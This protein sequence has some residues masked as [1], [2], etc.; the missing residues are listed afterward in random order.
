MGA[1]ATPRPDRWLKRAEGQFHNQDWTEECQGVTH[2]QDSWYLSSNKDGRQGVYRLSLTHQ[3]LGFVDLTGNGSGHLGDI[4]HHQGRIY[5]A[6]EQPVKI[7]VIE[8]TGPWT[9]W[10][11][12]L[13]GEQGQD[14]PQSD[15]PWCAVHPWN[16]LLYSSDFG[17]DA[18]GVSVL[19]AYRLDEPTRQFRHVPAEDITLALPVRRVQG[20]A[21]S[22]NGHVV[23]ASDHTDDIRC[24]STLN[25][26]Y[27]GRA[28]I[29]KDASKFEEVEGITI[30]KD[31][32]YD[33]QPT[34]VHVI[35]LDNDW[36]DGDDIYF[37]HYQVPTAQTL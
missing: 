31:V 30:W 13:R 10:P 8:A 16:G 15:C 26:A 12:D 11:V 7:I 25:G 24:F 27:R 9:W 2:D 29:Q 28:P 6:M 22:D 37:K 32:S 34:Q 14:P 20:A 18:P 21:F 23:I 1:M 4:D 3:Q 5:C 36:P 35:L 33:G 17:N 19:R